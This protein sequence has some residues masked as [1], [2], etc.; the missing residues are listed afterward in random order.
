M[1]CSSIGGIGDEASP[2]PRPTT[3]QWWWPVQGHWLGS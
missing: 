2:G 3:A 1:S